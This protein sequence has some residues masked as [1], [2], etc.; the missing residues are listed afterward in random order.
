MIT[1]H[2]QPDGSQRAG[3]KLRCSSSTGKTVALPPVIAFFERLR[4]R[5]HRWAPDGVFQWSDS[6]SYTPNDKRNELKEMI[7]LYESGAVNSVELSIEYVCRCGD[8]VRISRIRC[9][10][11]PDEAATNAPNTPF[12]VNSDSI[13]SV[14]LYVHRNE[15]EG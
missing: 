12:F 4:W 6:N 10:S 3:S 9:R 8:F 5:L 11:F 15:R 13:E 1:W 14:A 7:Q 2:K